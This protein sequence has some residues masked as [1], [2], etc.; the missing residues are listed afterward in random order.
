MPSSVSQVR[1]FPWL[2]R[3][4]DVASCQTVATSWS[5]CFCLPLRLAVS[6]VSDVAGCTCLFWFLGSAVAAELIISHSLSFR[7][8]RSFCSVVRRSRATFLFP[9]FT[10][11]HPQL[12]SNPVFFF[13]WS[14]IFRPVLCIFNKFLLNF[15]QPTLYNFMVL[16]IFSFFFLRFYCIYKISIFWNHQ[17]QPKASF[18]SFWPP[19]TWMAS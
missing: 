13:G 6:W 14:A 7:L 17:L 8:Q 16:I 9:A 10:A 11:Y 12:H 5:G 3:R 19:G 1:C 4:C 2:V 18:S 15:W